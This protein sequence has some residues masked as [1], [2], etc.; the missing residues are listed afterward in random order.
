MTSF[1]ADENIP[2]LSIRVLRGAG[3]HVL[4]VRDHHPAISDLPCKS[5]YVRASMLS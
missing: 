3:H 5:S 1:L 2:Y 4:A